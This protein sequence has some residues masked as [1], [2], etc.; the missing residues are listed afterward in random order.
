MESA[1]L[2]HGQSAKQNPYHAVMQQF[3]LPTQF[4]KPVFRMAV[5]L[6]ILGVI[7]ATLGSFIYLEHGYHDLK[8]T[9]IDIWMG[10]I[11]S[12]FLAIIE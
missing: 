7:L 5:V 1:T 3:I 12:I 9:G 6:I 8:R 4:R 11:V 10:I 2:T